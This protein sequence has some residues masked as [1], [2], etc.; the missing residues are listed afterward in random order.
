[1]AAV[2]TAL[3][4]LS[5]LVNKDSRLVMVN[6]DS[7]L[8]YFLVKLASDLFAAEIWAV[9]THHLARHSDSKVGNDFGSWNNN[10]L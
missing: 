5:L 8:Y 1:M 10:F 4:S 9:G 3:C 6:K 7:R 2:G